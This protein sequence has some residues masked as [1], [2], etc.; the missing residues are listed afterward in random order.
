MGYLADWKRAKES[1]ERVTGRSKPSDKFMGAFRKASG[2]ED[3]CK[4]LDTAESS[5]N[6]QKMVQAEAAYSKAFNAYNTTLTKA[7]AGERGAEYKSEV[8]KLQ[9]TLEGFLEEFVSKK[10]KARKEL[11]NSMAKEAKAVLEKLAAEF[12]DIQEVMSG[13]EKQEALSNAATVRIVGALGK[14]DTDKAQAELKKIG[15]CAKAAGEHRKE[16]KR[17]IAQSEA[18]FERAQDGFDVTPF[19]G[20]S[21]PVSANMDKAEMI[22]FAMR[23]FPDKAEDAV[24]SIEDDLKEG[25]SAIKSGVDSAKVY[26]ASVKKLAKRGIDLIR[27]VDADIRYVT[28]ELDKADLDRINASESTNPKEKDQLLDNARGAVQAQKPRFKNIATMIEKGEAELTEEL[29]GYPKGMDT[30]DAFA[31]YKKDVVSAIKQFGDMKEEL[32]AAIK[33][34]TKIEGKL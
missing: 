11:F 31:D 24:A 4:L 18:A 23:E 16:L 10:T 19:Q 7:L 32:K 8:K 26:V 14:H 1:F 3:A 13:I 17:L 22:L 20:G 29:A 5:G 21:N 6:Q 9:D 2:I 33:Q 15:D 27:K 25:K 30:V 28:G 12:S 34:A